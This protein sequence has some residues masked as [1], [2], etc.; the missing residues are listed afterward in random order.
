MAKKRVDPKLPIPE[1]GVDRAAVSDSYDD[2][3][4]RRL[5]ELFRDMDDGT[6]AVFDEETYIGQA[7]GLNF[8]GAGV[9]ATQAANLPVGN[10]D[11]TIPGGSVVL[12]SAVTLLPMRL[13]PDACPM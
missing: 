6:I 7:S 3:L 5:N 9:T 4:L 8:T 12:C 11:I 2:R 1:P 10:Y 13:T